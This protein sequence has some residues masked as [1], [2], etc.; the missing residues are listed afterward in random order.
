MK[1]EPVV[2]LEIHVQAKTKSKMFTE[3]DARYFGAE[4]NSHVDAY[5]MGLPGVLPVPNQEGIDQCL[6]I[7]LALNCKINQYSRFDRKNYFYPDLPKGYQISQYE[8]PFG[9]NGY[10]EVDVEG[11]SRRIRI[12]RVH[13]E[14]DTGKSIHEGDGTLLDYNKAG[15]PLV[16]IVTE[17]DFQSLKEVTAFAKLLRQTV[18]Y[19]GVSDAEMQKG[20]MRFEL[21]ISLRS[22]K[23]TGKFP[24]WK[25]EVKNIGSISVLE[26]VLEYE[27]ARQEELLDRNEDI[28][29]Q[30]RGLHGMT[31]ET[32]FQRSKE[33]EDDYRYFPE[34]DMPPIITT[35]ENLE[36]L[37]AELPELPVDRKMRYISEWRLEPDQA[38]V[39][40]DQ[41]EKGDWMDELNGKLSEENLKEAVKWFIGE[42]SGLMEKNSIAIAELPLKHTD[43]IY[44]IESLKSNKIS[45]T[46]MKK[47]LEILFK[48]GGT[49]EEIIKDRGMEQISDESDIKNLVQKAVDDNQK[50]VDSLSKN[51]NAYKALIGI[52]MRE[53]K[54]QANPQ[55]VEKML[56]E[57][58]SIE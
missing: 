56:K 11:D 6:K 35:D 57:L 9:H 14:E 20:Q 21:N 10:L 5:S 22:E 23:D 2:G 28:P 18:I 4:P 27:F 58:L 40:V 53:S 33:S 29:N 3:V 52:V 16:E 12:R 15:V 19:A 7:A 36:E 39:L 42:I 17:P 1:Y 43:L 34:P 45:G 32:V 24:D 30:T 31:G 54:G 44:L 41:K 13:L 25:V 38:E 51:P 55:M 26:K 50:I 8:L 49:A 47:V 46:I 37:K 48:E